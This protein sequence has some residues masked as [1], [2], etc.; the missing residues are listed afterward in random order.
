ME[1]DRKSGEKFPKGVLH[2]QCS[3]CLKAETDEMNEAF[4]YEGDRTLLDKYKEAKKKFG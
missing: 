3:A 2:P 1:N 4:L